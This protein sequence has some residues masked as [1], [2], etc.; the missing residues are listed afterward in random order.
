M[1]SYFASR[2]RGLLFCSCD[3]RTTAR[4]SRRKCKDKRVLNLPR[5]SPSSPSAMLWEL[6]R[7]LKK[8]ADHTYTVGA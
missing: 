8:S 6:D 2:R 1:I 5:Q 4:A 3:P 7:T